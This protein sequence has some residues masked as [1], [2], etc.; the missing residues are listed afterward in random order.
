MGGENTWKSWNLCMELLYK[1]QNAG[2][3]GGENANYRRL[4]HLGRGFQKFRWK[5]KYGGKVPSAGPL[6]PNPIQE[7]QKKKLHHFHHQIQKSCVEQ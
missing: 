5:K 2:K 7:N 3:N 4:F 1:L 6:C